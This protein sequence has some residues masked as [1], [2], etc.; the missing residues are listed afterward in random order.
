MEVL[1]TKEEW[2]LNLELAIANNKG[3]MELAPC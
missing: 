3:P 2:A 1:L